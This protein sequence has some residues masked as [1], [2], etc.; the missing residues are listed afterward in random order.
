MKNKLFFL[1][2]ILGLILLTN[3]TNNDS[4]RCILPSANI[5]SNGPVISGNAIKLQTVPYLIHND[6]TYQWTGPN[7]FQSS[8]ANPIINNATTSMAGEY[9]LKVKKGICES[10]EVKVYV[11]VINNTVNCNQT[12]DTALFS[13]LGFIVSF[14]FN[15]AKPTANDNFEIYGGSN[16]ISISVIFKSTLKPITGIY[17]IVNKAIPLTDGKVHV[18]MT[19]NS[20]LQYFAN[21][22]DVLVYYDIN[23]NAVVKFCNIPFSFSTNTSTDSSGSAKFIQNQ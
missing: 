9:K 23:N 21:S 15:T 22:G 13:H 5:S 18:K 14:Y 20:V 19:Q 3:C 16:N 17:Q 10:E 4:D 2:C 6:V 12:D 8:L 7:G 11:A 1:I